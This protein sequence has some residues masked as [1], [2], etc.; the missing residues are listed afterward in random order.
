MERSLSLG[1]EEAE[2][3]TAT[4]V[5][6]MIE[7]WRHGECP[8]PEEFFAQQPDLWNH[9]EAATDLIY[10]EMCLRQEY[11]QEIPVEEVLSRFPQWRPQLEVLFDCQRLLGP[12]SVAPLFPSVGGSLGDF[13][14]LAELGGG[15][16]GRVFLATQ[17]SLGGRPVVL[18]LI[19]LEACEHLSLA[20]LQHTHIVP[21]FSVQDHPDRGLRSLCM[22]YFGGAT[23]TQVFEALRSWPVSQRTGQDLLDALIRTPASQ[24]FASLILPSFSHHGGERAFVMPAR[25]A[26]VKANYVEALC[27]IGAC[28][29][30]AL[31][32]AHERG[33]I[34]LDLKPSNVLLTADGQPMVLDFHLAREPIRGGPSSSSGSDIVHQPE[35]EWLGGT[36]GY[37]SPE[38]QAAMTAIQ[39]GRPVPATVDGRSDIYSLGLVLYEALGGAPQ[40]PGRKLWP[41]N[42]CNSQVSVGLADIVRKCLASNP[43][44][45]YPDMAALATDLRR[46]LAHRPLLG[47]SNRS[48]LERWKKWRKRRPHSVAFVAMLLAV[49]IAAAT[50]VF[51]AGRIYSQRVDQARLT[52]KVG[53]KQ[54]AKGEWDTA[55][56]T[57]QCGLS[58]A[59]GLPFQDALADELNQRLHLADQGRIAGNR[60]NAFNYLHDLADQ[61]RFLY[62]S[63]YHCRERIQRLAS[64]CR[65]FWGKRRDVVARLTDNGNAPL[66]PPVRD[67]LVDLAI[68]WSDMQEHVLFPTD[69]EKAHQNA[70]QV[71]SEAEAFFG[72][73]PALVKKRRLYGTPD[74]NDKT[75][76]ASNSVYSAPARASHFR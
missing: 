50:V 2:T 3:L 74:P 18:K 57:L 46:H 34:H 48:A 66:E 45:R 1:A 6:E 23:L 28:L 19:P 53:D 37:M 13:L 52:L 71:L 47:V 70:L 69:K 27:W 7:R 9:P 29:A 49:F 32:Y 30:E 39:M 55:I 36:A 17:A 33:L 63:N 20:R 12:G 58:M 73:S 15:V 21:V 26:L 22:P 54:M 38:Q 14:L 35:L 67:D 75:G 61:A 42:R 65:A 43:D 60:A 8:L 72:P 10:E 59:R 41:L 68:F 24:A 25:R 44:G 56:G 40:R 64:S 11:G 16:H 62:G 4:L 76:K 31:Q 51:G 5:E